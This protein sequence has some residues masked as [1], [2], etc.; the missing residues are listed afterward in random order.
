MI[1]RSHT[2]AIKKSYG[3]KLPTG[4]LPEIIHSHTTY[5]I[6]KTYNNYNKFFVKS[7]GLRQ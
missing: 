1:K 4:V 6:H 5:G 7:Q 2:K 3:W